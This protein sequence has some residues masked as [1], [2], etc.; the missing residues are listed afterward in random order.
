MKNVK[1]EILADAIATAFEFSK[2]III[3]QRII[4]G[5]CVLIACLCA[6]YFIR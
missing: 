4:I 5:L 1:D 6:G 3:L 2:K